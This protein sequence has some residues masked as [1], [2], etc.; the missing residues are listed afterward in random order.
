MAEEGRAVVVGI[1]LEERARAIDKPWSPVEVARVNDQVVRLAKIQGEY[2]W[3]KHANEDELFYVFKGGIII[4]LKDQPDIALGEGEMAIIPKG[5]EHRPKS[6]GASYILM[7]EPYS[8][9][10]RGD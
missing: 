9:D 7:F 5:V 4:Q 1:S 8:L 2:H 3:H 6:E 10:S